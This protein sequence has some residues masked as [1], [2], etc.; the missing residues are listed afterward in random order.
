MAKRRLALALLVAL[1]ISGGCTFVLSRKM[2]IYAA[3]KVPT[4]RY[5]A[6][7]VQLEAGEVL[8][9]EDIKMVDWPA[10]F[11][12]QGW[13]AKP[14]EVL[15]RSVL[16][17]LAANEPI[18]DRD[19]AAPGSGIGLTAEIPDGMRAIALRSDE[20]VGVA[21]FL[22]PGCHVD[23]LITYRTDQSPELTTSTV[24]QDAEVLAAGHQIQPTQDGKPVT[25]N[26]VTLLMSPEDA[27]RVV[28]ASTQ[29]TIH[30]VLRNSEDHAQIEDE[31]VELSQLSSFPSP[32]PPAEG[33]KARPV[34]RKPYVVET[35]L[36]DKE[37][38]TSFN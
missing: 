19:L 35:M 26:V 4:E 3:V 21:G 12:L 18:L 36:G 9:P 2:K 15:G 33:R 17:A 30:F 1:V 24:L 22:F 5:I 7:A 27:E 32:K 37:I 29:G 28:L 25:V 31:P 16:Y 34:K 8:K 23:V 6:T 11:P 20:V 14:Q 13:F 10:S 38:Y